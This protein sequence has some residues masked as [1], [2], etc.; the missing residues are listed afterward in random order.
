MSCGYFWLVKLI[1]GYD[2]IHKMDM[3]DNKSIQK[4]VK[5]WFQFWKLNAHFKKY[6]YKYKQ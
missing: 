3:T 4:E 2:K 6:G 5:I 1:C